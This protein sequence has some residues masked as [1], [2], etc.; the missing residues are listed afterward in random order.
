[1]FFICYTTIKGSF[2]LNENSKFL[3][4]FVKMAH[5]AP[6]SIGQALILYAIV[7]W[8]FKSKNKKTAQSCC[9]DFFYMQGFHQVD[10]AT[11]DKWIFLLNSEINSF[12]K[13]VISKKKGFQLFQFRSRYVHP[14]R[15]SKQVI[16]NILMTLFF[17]LW[18]FLGIDLVIIV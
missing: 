12:K 18:H 16:V 15:I 2:S 6:K 14:T 1:M 10:Y 4:G 3:E 17:Y 7:L 8:L 11:N 13:W 9:T 5:C